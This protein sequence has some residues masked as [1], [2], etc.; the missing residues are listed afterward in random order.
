MGSLSY[1][2]IIVLLS[3]VGLA[4]LVYESPEER[5]LRAKREE[6][7]K[8][9]V[10]K[11]LAIVSSKKEAER[12]K[13]NGSIFTVI[14]K[15]SIPNYHLRPLGWVKYECDERSLAEKE[16]V[17][18]AVEKFEKANILSK[19]SYHLRDE[20]YQADTSKNGNPYFRNRK[21]K[22]WEAQ[23]S[24][25]ILLK[26]VDKPSIRWN[27]KLA[28]VDGCNVIHWGIGALPWSA[29]S[30]TIGPLQAVVDILLKE[31]IRPII[32]FDASIGRLLG[33]NQ[34]SVDS[35]SDLLKRNVEIEIVPSGTVADHR[36]SELAYE[37]AAVIVT[38][39]LFR[40]SVRARHIPKRRG[41]YV[42]GTA[43]LLPP[44]A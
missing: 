32:V 23:A 7:A 35:L 34:V 6:D 16:L 41:Y 25:A 24:E 3:I 38:N 17:T 19:L 10:L 40:D 9:L 29:K 26:E 28:L 20:K 22:V 44:R 42:D 36:L 2:V 43:E 18:L 31:N 12:L 4:F 33:L 1:F 27:V 37:N 21:I 11:K 30:P 15:E 39:D 8:K 13:I 5:Q 14:T